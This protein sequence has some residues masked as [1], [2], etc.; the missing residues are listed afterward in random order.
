MS[1]PLKLLLLS[2]TFSEHTEKWALGLANKGV[3]VGLF[4]F[5]KASYEWYNHKNITVFFE[6]DNKINAEST[7]TKLS[8]IKYVSI[9]K[10]IIKHFNP[11]ILHAHYATS[12]GLIG[13]LSRFRPF[14]LSVW[15]S[16]IYDFPIKSK[17]HKKVIQYNLSKADVIMSTSHVMKQEILKYTKKEVVVTPFGVDV[18]TFS[19]KENPLKKADTIYIGTIKPIEEKYG[20]TTIINAAKLVVEKNKAFNFKFL[21]IGSS[22]NI[23]VYKSQIE[24][25]QLT[26][27]FE[28][29]GRIPFS[30][31]S[32]YHNLLDIF[33][34]VSID[35]SE[36]FGV[37]AVEAMACEKPVIVT[38][39]GGLKEVVNN[40]EFGSVI[41]KNNPEALANAITEI[42]TNKEK[43]T[44]IGIKARQHVLNL[45]NWDNNLE[46]MVN[47]YNK[48]T[49]K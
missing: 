40:G 35:D 1:H 16:D 29:T 22:N 20:I 4:S 34:N 15:G 47:E 25:L 8:Y 13:A 31:I 43:A 36:S 48:L 32:A 24:E 7:L 41:P 5:N 2:D 39:V 10:K 6:P 44:E 21:L 3:L 27:Y 19:K 42:I 28:I 38:D 11:D 12:Y 37:A 30:K 26:D 45:Y 18:N 14:F 17:L 9:L 49:L 46:L 23:D 33:L